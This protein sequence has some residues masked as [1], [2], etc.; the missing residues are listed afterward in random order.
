MS[1]WAGRLSTT[2]PKLILMCTGAAGASL[3][4]GMSLMTG[5]AGPT[6][7]SLP[8][9]M[10]KG[11]AASRSVRKRETGTDSTDAL[12][13]AFTPPVLSLQGNNKASNAAR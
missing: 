2:W 1:G 10:D 11:E 13:H 6:P 3:F 4:E 7:H 5:A 12:E 9:K 8:S